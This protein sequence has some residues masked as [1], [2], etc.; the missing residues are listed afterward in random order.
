MLIDSKVCMNQIIVNPAI[1]GFSK[2]FTRYG[3]QVFLEPAGFV[4]VGGRRW[5]QLGS[6]P[7]PLDYE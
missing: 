2:S 1:T 3:F 7:H 5:V 6:T 4:F